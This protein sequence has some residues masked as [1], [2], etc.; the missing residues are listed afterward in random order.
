MTDTLTRWLAGAAGL[1]LR[2]G[3]RRF[4]HDYGSEFDHSFALMLN[5]ERQRRGVGPML[6]LWSRGLIDVLKAVVRE[7]HSDRAGQG[8]AP[9]GDLSGDLRAALR[10]G[11]RA[12]GFSVTIVLTLVLGLGLAS[13]I[14]AFADGY[15]F[16][17]LPFPA[18]E[19]LF[20]VRDPDGLAGSLKASET[21]ALRATTVGPLGFVEWGGDTPVPA[22]GDL[23][24]G[25]R[26]V[27]VRLDGVSPGFAQ[28]LQMPLAAGRVFTSQDYVSAVH[29]PAWLSYR[30]WEREFGRDRSVLGRTFTIVGLSSGEGTVIIVGIMARQ[31]TAFDLYDPPPDLVTPSI[32]LAHP[33]P[34]LL[35]FPIVR[36]PGAMT[37]PQA[38]AAISAA[39]QAITPAPAGNVRHVRLSS[40]YEYQVQGGR[41]TAQVFLTGA[42]LVLALVTIN[43]I[44]L[45]L[46]RGVARAPEIATRVA[47]GASRWRIARLFLVESLLLGSLGIAG[48]LVLGAWLATLIAAAVPTFPTGA[49]NLALVTMTFDA[50]AVG[51]AAVLG[52]VISTCGGAWPAWRAV[53]RPRVVA[54]RGPRGGGGEMS[55]RLSRAMLASEVAV[56]TVIMVGTVFM[57]LGIWR[58]LNQPLGFE[59]QDRLRVYLYPRTGSR[60]N[61][62]VVDWAATVEAVRSAPGVRAAAVERPRSAGLIR[63]GDEAQTRR[64]IGATDVG[65]GYFEAWGLRLREGRVFLPEE[66]PADAPVA[67]VDEKFAQ[68][69]WPGE[70]PIGKLLRV[71]DGPPRQVVGIVAH[72][73][74]SLSRETPGVAYVPRPKIDLRESLV[75]WAPG[76][77]PSDLADRVAGPLSKVVP[78]VRAVVS[79]ITFENMFVRD[80]GEAYF[81]RPVVVVFGLFAFV[82]AGV[83]LF[84]LVTYLVEQ[85][86]RDFGIR[87]ALGARPAD[88]WRQVVGQSTMP[89]AVGLAAGLTAARALERVVR[90]SVFGWESSGI[91]AMIAVSLALLSVAIIAATGPARRALRIDPIQ[92]LRAE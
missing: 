86:T 5:Q 69:V 61:Q 81:Q 41:P 18:P 50:R 63:A 1:V 46:T 67:V 19:R 62:A 47:L 55:A 84:G 83:G 14:F 53:R 10:A 59:L 79:P 32:E 58:Y 30:F 45:L 73:R 48:G 22:F 15:L 91:A 80:A 20:F 42:C 21:V 6:A 72:E 38:E 8:G 89:A 56:A 12:P 44:H 71:K 28:L 90:A 76:V 52:L 57:S 74:R 78:S 25:D 16:R 87:L 35:S 60:G 70:D 77:G 49:R 40:L 65:Q 29:V 54:N 31:V 88:I 85:R 75:V 24:L 17:P 11:R 68:L 7:W 39:L 9:L 82:L 37:Q 2:L 3:P 13:A 36:L 64:D 43:L 92:V 23:L 51:V 26:R 34:N 27:Q 33:G 4:R 66:V